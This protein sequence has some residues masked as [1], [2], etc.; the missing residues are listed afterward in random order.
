MASLSIPGY[1]DESVGRAHVIV[2]EDARSF[3]L[4]AIA[5][6]GTLYSFA[7]N[8]SEARAFEGRTT[9]YVMPGS[10]SRP[11]IVRHLT[12]GG[13][14]RAITGD[15]FLWRDPPRPFNELKLAVKLS[16]EGILTPEVIAAVVHRA[17]PLYRGDIARRWIPDARDLADCLFGEPALSGAERITVLE[18]AGRLVRS[19]HAAGIVHPDLNARNILIEWKEGSPRAYILDLEKCRASDD[20]SASQ[21]RRMLARLERALAKLEK[22]ADERLAADERNA[23]RAAYEEPES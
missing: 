5:G 14:L 23:F 13:A 18:A 19:L 3:V 12:H 16:S 22:L 8:H 1:A 11:W 15:R 17:G 20:L 2:R 6:H 7:A 10:D 21:R 4:E 9:V